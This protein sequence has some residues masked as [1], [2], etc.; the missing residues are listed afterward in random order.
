MEIQSDLIILPPSNHLP[1]PWSVRGPLGLQTGAEVSIM[2]V[3]SNTGG[4]GLP[5][6]VVTPLQSEYLDATF[7]LEIE[8]GER[9]GAVTDLLAWLGDGIAQRC[10]NNMNIVL[11]ETITLEGRN[12]HK[13]HVVMEPASDK[14]DILE[15]QIRQIMEEIQQSHADVLNYRINPVYQLDKLSFML[16]QTVPVKHGWIRYGDW[17]KRIQE[18]FPNADEVYDLSRVVVSSNP[19]QRLLR[20]IIPKKGV[21][22][23]KVPHRNR[24]G[25]LREI[26]RVIGGQGYNILSSRLS[27]T[28]P[29]ERT[30]KTSVFVAAC[31]PLKAG[32][33]VKE[34][35]FNELRSKL[36]AI[37]SKY[38][39]D[40]ITINEGKLAEK[41]LFLT[42]KRKE[43]VQI[44][45]EIAVERAQVREEASTKFFFEA[46]SSSKEVCFLVQALY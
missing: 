13:M 28:P 9:A 19:D 5:D 6:I 30:A 39:I 40:A 36:R 31:E 26:S 2:L 3:Q 34:T 46:R 15:S 18:K 11:S 33:Q 8:L 1:L 35:D 17:K 10:S 21:I 7:A 32:G 24:P 25:A 37:D 12:K 16:Q 45:T 43:L 42:P 29:T 41:S 44:D 14:S 4:E 22:E 38:S 23:L 20:Y 27:R